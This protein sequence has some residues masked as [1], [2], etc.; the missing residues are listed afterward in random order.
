[1]QH[2]PRRVPAHISSRVVQTSVGQVRWFGYMKLFY[3][4]HAEVWSLVTR[5]ESGEGELGRGRIVTPGLVG[6]K[7]QKHSC[8]GQGRLWMLTPETERDVGFYSC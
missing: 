3:T 4:S 2:R 1:M 8:V 6:G 5:T 7:E